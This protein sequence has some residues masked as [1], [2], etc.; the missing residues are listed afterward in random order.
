MQFASFLEEVWVSFLGRVTLEVLVEVG[1]LG[2]LLMFQ[3]VLH[4]F[5]LVERILGFHRCFPCCRHLGMSQ[6]SS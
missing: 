1:V 3:L 2:F 6:F 4:E 5:G